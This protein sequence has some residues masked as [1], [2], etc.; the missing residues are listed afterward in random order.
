MTTA[1]D[2]PTA[3]PV[4]R[5]GTALALAAVLTAAATGAP[6][7]Q[8]PPDASDLLSGFAGSIELRGLPRPAV[9]APASTG[10]TGDDILK[11]FA[12]CAAWVVNE[13]FA[14]LE[15]EGSASR[16]V[17]RATFWGCAYEDGWPH[18]ALGDFIGNPVDIVESVMS[19]GDAD[20]NAAVNI[21]GLALFDGASPDTVLPLVRRTNCYS[22]EN[23]W[24]ALHMA[25]TPSAR[26]GL[27]QPDAVRICGE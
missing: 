4:Y 7:A 17:T 9:P 12:E 22:Y 21:A 5:P 23:L 6:Q 13:V 14:A 24:V 27:T 18:Q 2:R 3:A 19:G 20:I 16:S 1:P 8:Q 26:R 15:D 25:M 10:L 11:R